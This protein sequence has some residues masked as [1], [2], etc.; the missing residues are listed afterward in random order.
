MVHCGEVGEREG[1]REGGGSKGGRKKVVGRGRVGGI[2][3]K[4]EREHDF[5]QRHHLMHTHIH[6]GI[7]CM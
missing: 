4:R 3:R 5:N 1:G 2:E 6:C 7:R